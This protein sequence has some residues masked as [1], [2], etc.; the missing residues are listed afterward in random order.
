MTA[1]LKS[2]AYNHIRAQM[3]TGELA[4]GGFFSPRQIAK[5]IGMSYTPV[6]EA[7]IQLETEGLLEKVGNRGV[8]MRHLAPEEL[9]TVFELRLVM[10]TGAAEIAAEKIT[11]REIGCLKDNIRR[12]LS[13]LK[14]LREQ[15]RRRQVTEDSYNQADD[16]ILVLNMEF[17]LT[18]LNATRN[19]ALI[20]NIGDLRI[21]TRVVNT[22]VHFPGQD[23]LDQYLRDFRFHFRIYQAF[24]R[25]SADGAREWVKRHLRNAF[26]YNLAIHRAIESTMSSEKR[27]R[28]LYPESLLESMRQIESRLSEPNRSGNS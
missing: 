18:I 15:G 24:C 2:Q 6:R 27:A 25:R 23:Y 4:E 28:L 1:N 11:D 20:K 14:D 8:R 16:R 10:E 17:H 5:T 22:R 12:H 21:L 3:I 19:T 9:A 13:V 26:E 7:V